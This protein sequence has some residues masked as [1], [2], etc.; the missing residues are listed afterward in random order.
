MDTW[1]GKLPD[2]HPDGDEQRGVERAGQRAAQLEHPDDHDRDDQEV[3]QQRD[4]FTLGIDPAPGNDQLSG[5]RWRRFSGQG[6]RF[7][8]CVWQA[9][10][11]HAR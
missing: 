10:V 3:E 11:V 2:H 8:P 4:P 9:A 6:R 7:H 1:R 5:G